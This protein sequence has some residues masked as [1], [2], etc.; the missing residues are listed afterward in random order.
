MR[1]GG[2]ARGLADFGGF[3]ADPGVAVLAG[4]AVAVA[5][6]GEDLGVVDEPVD[7][8]AKTEAGER[9]IDLDA[10]LAMK[11]WERGADATVPM[12]TTASGKRL[13][14]RNLRRVL[15]AACERVGVLGVSFHT[16]RHTHGSMMI[17]EGW[18]IPEV[19]ERLGHADPGVTARV[20]SHKLRDRRREVPSFRGAL[21][22]ETRS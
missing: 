19:S 9:T 6:E 2:R 12:F 17:D 8:R 11:L 3:G 14:D 1:R 10:E 16:F 4:Q 15:D 21:A 18:T 13:S 20:Y 22:A 7:H 5:F